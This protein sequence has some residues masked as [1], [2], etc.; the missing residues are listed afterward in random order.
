MYERAS[1]RPCHD[2]ARHGTRFRRAGTIDT[3]VDAEP[4][5]AAREP[6]HF[7]VMELVD[8]TYTPPPMELFP[9][10][11]RFGV[12]GEGA[13][14]R[15]VLVRSVGDLLGAVVSRGWRAELEA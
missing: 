10:I 1:S 3:L 8:G 5:S 11:V 4:E 7:L 12:L 15:F 6:V 9:A 14:E 13:A 2:P